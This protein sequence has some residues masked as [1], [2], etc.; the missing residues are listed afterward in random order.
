MSGD[1]KVF[2]I[3]NEFTK[4]VSLPEKLKKEGFDVQ[5]GSGEGV[6]GKIVSQKPDLIITCIDK[7]VAMGQETRFIKELKNKPELKESEIF[8]CAENI[9]VG[10]EVQLRGLKLNN[11]FQ[12]DDDTGFL[13][14]SVVTY[15]NPE[16]VD[17]EDPF[18]Y[19]EP[20]EPVQAPRAPAPTAAPESP[21][22]PPPPPQTDEERFGDMFGEFSDKV[23]EQ[24]GDKDGETYYNLGVSYMDMGLHKE[25]IKEFLLAAKD[26][27]FK[28][29]STSMMGIC[30]RSLG[31]SK[32][33]VAMFQQG[34]KISKDPVEVMGFR[35]EIGVTLQEMG[36]LK[37]AF[38]FLAAVYK[39]DK[40]YRDTRKKL[41]EIKSSLQAQKG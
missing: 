27:Q 8:V 41:V 16:E 36:K 10:L 39:A 35:Y 11:Y 15:F 25:A 22:T 37:E 23:H 7:S 33:A 9:S 28:L 38:N 14:K 24:L 4:R 1:K 29:E 13:V 3:E 12:Q 21:A 40:N 5:L 30:M 18:E 17:M 32:E 6:L 19:T 31:K 2:V 20:D 26:E 34:T